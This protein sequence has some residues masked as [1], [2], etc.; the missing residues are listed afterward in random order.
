MNGWK[1][2]PTETDLLAERLNIRWLDA[3][4]ITRVQRGM[5]TSNKVVKFAQRRG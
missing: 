2:P 4:R 5:R 1:P 3:A